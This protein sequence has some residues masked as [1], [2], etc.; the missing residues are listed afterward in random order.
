MSMIPDKQDKH[1]RRSGLSTLGQMLILV[2]IVVCAMC[3]TFC[4]WSMMQYRKRRQL[5]KAN[6]QRQQQQGDVCNDSQKGR[7]YVPPNLNNVTQIATAPEQSNK[8][9]ARKYRGREGINEHMNDEP[10]RG[11]GN[12]IQRGRDN[13]KDKNSD[14][15][16][17]DIYDDRY[18]VERVMTTGDDVTGAANHANTDTGGLWQTLA[19]P[20]QFGT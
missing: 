2:G 7:F 13:D 5:L 15:N 11:V 8:R 14:S 10:G 16:S 6:T 3:C 18:N 1:D 12:A 4:V 17:D 19:P 9:N 20:P